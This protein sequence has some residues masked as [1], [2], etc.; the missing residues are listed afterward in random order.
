[1]MME[2]KEISAFLAFIFFPSKLHGTFPR[3]LI[4]AKLYR[5]E[6]HLSADKDCDDFQQI[7]E[8]WKEPCNEIGYLA[9]LSQYVFELINGHFELIFV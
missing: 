1:M 3:L 4:N 5:N 6:N 7:S 9:V 8:I 2:K